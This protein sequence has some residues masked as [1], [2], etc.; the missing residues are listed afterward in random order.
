[1]IRRVPLDFDWPLHMRWKGYVN[2]YSSQKCQGCQGTGYNPETRRLYHSWFDWQHRLTQDEVDELVRQDR[3][4]P[5]VFSAEAVNEWSQNSAFGHDEINRVICV[6]ARAKRRDVFGYCPI[7]NG[8]GEVWFSDRVKQ[9]AEDWEKDE[10]YDPPAGEG[11][12]LWETISEGSPITPV[13]ESEKEL[14]AWI[15]AEKLTR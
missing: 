8:D 2:P 10:R 12:Q 13:F 5:G 11:W 15:K 9:L 3:L 1:M 14:K 6:E 4:L 7:C